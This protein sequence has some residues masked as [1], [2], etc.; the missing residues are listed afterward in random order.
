MNIKEND[1]FLKYVKDKD[2][3]LFKDCSDDE[4]STVAGL[5]LISTIFGIRFSTDNSSIVSFELL[6]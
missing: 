4:R 3:N 6:I 2:I 1:E 5:T